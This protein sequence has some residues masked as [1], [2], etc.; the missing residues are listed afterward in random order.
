MK[1]WATILSIVLGFLTILF[2]QYRIQNLPHGT[3]DTV[4]VQGQ[5][6][7]DSVFVYDTIHKNVSI[8]K[9]R[10]TGSVYC[11][12]DTVVNNVEQKVGIVRFSD[13]SNAFVNVSGIV[14]WPTGGTR[15]IYDNKFDI[16]S[17]ENRFKLY[18]GFGYGNG[19]GGFGTVNASYK[20]YQ[21]GVLFGQRNTIGFYIG[22]KF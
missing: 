22:K 3:T 1:K 9:Y 20:K 6:L 4:F 18:Y 2:Q 21:A 14:A 16:E 15:L 11:S 10:D 5:V 19:I 8:V 12:I 7:T 17:F 13:S